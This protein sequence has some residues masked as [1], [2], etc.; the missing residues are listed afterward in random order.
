MPGAAADKEA[1]PDTSKE[2]AYSTYSEKA[3]RVTVVVGSYQ[4]GMD[5]QQQFAPVQVA[6]GAEGRGPELLVKL[7]SFLL[8][9]A[10]G[11]MYTTAAAG[12]I[13]ARSSLIRQS[14]AMAE[15]EPLEQSRAM[16]LILD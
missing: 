9:D 11:N 16:N 12:E 2:V 14:A 8:F 15:A 3:G 6:V 7:D 1:K 5:A 13:T 4:T 10:D